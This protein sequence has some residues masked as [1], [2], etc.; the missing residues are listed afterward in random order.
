MDRE[1]AIKK[2]SEKYS[3]PEQDILDLLKKKSGPRNSMAFS[4]RRTKEVSKAGYV[5]K[6]EKVSEGKYIFTK[7]DFH[8]LV[9]QIETVTKEIERVGHEIGDSTADTK[10]FHDNFEYE[11]LGRQQRMWTNR[12]HSLKK[13]REN[14]RIIEVKPSSEFVSIGSRVKIEW[15]GGETVIKRIGSYITFSDDDLSYDSPL[16]KL[17]LGKRAG[18]EVHG[19][20]GNQPCHVVIKA[21]Y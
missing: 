17:L 14:V 21:I 11:E 3:I 18:D 13:F 4:P 7:S 10:T 12:L 20:I 8:L 9:K 2:I 16:A 15:K 5:I 6:D 19:K 1:T